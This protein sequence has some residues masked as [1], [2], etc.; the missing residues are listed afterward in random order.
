MDWVIG[1]HTKERYVLFYLNQC[2]CRMDLLKIKQKLWLGY[3]GRKL[4]VN[5]G[6]QQLA[7]SLL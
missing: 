1:G 6:E 3:V 5:S 7:C 2:R 4:K